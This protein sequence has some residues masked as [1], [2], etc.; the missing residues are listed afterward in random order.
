MSSKERVCVLYGGNSD[1]RAISIRSGKAIVAALRRQG[2]VVAG[3]DA[4]NG[5]LKEL[6][7]KKPDLI[8]IALHGKGGSLRID[9]GR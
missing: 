7:N 9:H 2:V 5:Y 3:V 8:F 4:K 6:Q 1:E